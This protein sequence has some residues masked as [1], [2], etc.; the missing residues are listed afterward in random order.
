MILYIGNPKD[1]TKQTD[2]IDKFSKVAEYKID[3]QKLV[4]FLYTNSEL[5]ERDIRKTPHLH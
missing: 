5:W 1:S 2:R 4:L 3:I